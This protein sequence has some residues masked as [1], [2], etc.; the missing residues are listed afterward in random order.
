MKKIIERSI[1]TDVSNDRNKRTDGVAVFSSKAKSLGV[2]PKAGNC[3]GC[4]G[5]VLFGLN[6]MF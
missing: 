6:L 1:N 5:T 2:T 4:G 3:S